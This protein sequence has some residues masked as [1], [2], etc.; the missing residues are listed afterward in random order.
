MLAITGG[1]LFIADTNNHQVRLADLQTRQ[2]HT[3]ELR[4]LERLAQASSR[5][6]VPLRLDPLQVGEGPLQITLELQLPAG[7]K[8]NPDTVTLLRV[9]EDGQIRELSFA[10][11]EAITFQAAPGARYELALDLT[12]YYCQTSGP[13]LC[14]VHEGSLAVPLEP[15]PGG[16]QQAT[17][18][19]GIDMPKWII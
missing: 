14:L 19:Y 5:A 9:S 17:I 4:G 13:G 16:P 12:V 3:L 7:Y 8:R 2:V 11:D 1:R 18:P 6:S 15:I 10:P